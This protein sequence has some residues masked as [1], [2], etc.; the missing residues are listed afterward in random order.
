MALIAGLS[1]QNSS[2]INSTST[3]SAPTLLPEKPTESN[4]TCPL[5][6][7]FKIYKTTDPKVDQIAFEHIN[8]SYVDIYVWSPALKSVKYESYSSKR[9]AE[10]HINTRFKYIGDATAGKLAVM[11]NHL[12]VA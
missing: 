12:L 11:V 10:K 7:S 5:V 1:E 6:Y 2:S 4:V 8:F 9:F 3:Y